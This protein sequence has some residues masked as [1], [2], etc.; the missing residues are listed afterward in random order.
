MWTPSAST[1][2]GENNFTTTYPLNVEMRA[3]DEEGASVSINQ[4]IPLGVY[5]ARPPLVSELLAIEV[6]TKT[7]RF[8]EGKEGRV[9]I[10]GKLLGGS[11]GHSQ[12]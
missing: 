7:P 11:F 5:V 9:V 10:L 3:T 8:T 1:I 6:G 2:T 4:T 12:C